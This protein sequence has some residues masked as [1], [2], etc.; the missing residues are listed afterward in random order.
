MIR[1][2]VSMV[3]EDGNE[4][5]E[6]VE[7]DLETVR[8]WWPDCPDEIDEERGRAI[9]EHIARGQWRV[10]YPAPTRRTVPHYRAPVIC[11]RIAA[12]PRERR[13]RRARSPS[14]SGGGDSSDSDDDPGPP[15]GGRLTPALARRCAS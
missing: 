1:A 2:T 4:W 12:R 13:S 11:R 7:F 3:D 14:S 6:P 5:E 10:R 8:S 9:L 15:V